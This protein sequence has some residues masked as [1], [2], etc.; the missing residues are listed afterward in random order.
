MLWGIVVLT[1]FGTG[2]LDRGIP[3]AVVNG[4][5]LALLDGMPAMLASISW[6]GVRGIVV[7]G[8]LA[9]TMLVNSSFLLG[10]SSVISQ[11][12]V[13]L[14]RQV[15]RGRCLAQKGEYWLIESVMFSSACSCCFG[16]FITRRWAWS[17]FI[18]RSQG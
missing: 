5:Q 15:M 12:I 6:T 2:V 8:M 16:G 11:D 18:G 4:E 17:I 14:L 1:M 9:A 10:W 7:A 13:L 3:S